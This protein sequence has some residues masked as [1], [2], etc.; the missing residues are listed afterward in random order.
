MKLGGW[1]DNID[2][3]NLPNVYSL[4][5]IFIIISLGS[6]YFLKII[7]IINSSICPVT[8]TCYKGRFHLKFL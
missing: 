6:F 2:L 7:K 5:S 4:I 1:H 3:Y 8:V